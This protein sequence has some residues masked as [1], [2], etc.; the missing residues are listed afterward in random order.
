MKDKLSDWM[1]PISILISPI[2][3]LYLTLFTNVKD[4]DIIGLYIQIT[5]ILI[6]ILTST[7]LNKLD[8]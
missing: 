8:K 7:I 6:G 2:P 3:W 5:I 1:G 4:K